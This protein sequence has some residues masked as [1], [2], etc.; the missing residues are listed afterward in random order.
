MYIRGMDMTNEIK[1]IELIDNRNL[2]F[3]VEGKW[4][5]AIFFNDGADAL[6]SFN[7]KRDAV[8]FMNGGYNQF[9][10]R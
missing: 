9:E 4:W 3:S 1:N 2:Q 7:L 5:V 10:L 8:W 6:M